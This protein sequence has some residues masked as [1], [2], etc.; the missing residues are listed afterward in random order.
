MHARK[1]RENPLLESAE[2]TVP[3]MFQS[4]PLQLFRKQ[5]QDRIAAELEYCRREQQDR[6]R[7][8]Q[9]VLADPTTTQ[10][11]ETGPAEFSTR[12]KCKSREL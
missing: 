6:I 1:V 11:Q 8:A 7:A 3:A 4:R 9:E 2:A 5:R 12:P 10:D